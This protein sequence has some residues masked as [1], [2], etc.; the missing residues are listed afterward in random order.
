MPLKIVVLLGAPYIY[1]HHYHYTELCGNQRDMSPSNKGE[2]FSDS[3][4]KVS[5]SQ[6]AKRHVFHTRQSQS[7]C[8]PIKRSKHI[9][10]NE[11]EIDGDMAFKNFAFGVAILLIGICG[12]AVLLSDPFLLFVEKECRDV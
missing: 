5:G 1:I 10:R 7:F 2:T 3:A 12:T 8:K 6:V 9:N 11:G 4:E